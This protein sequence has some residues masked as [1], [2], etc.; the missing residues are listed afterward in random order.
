MGQKIEIYYDGSCDVC[1]TGADKVCSSA[2]GQKFEKVDITTG[3]LPPNVTSREA[4]RDVYV[5]DQN[6]EVLKGGDGVL[7]VL[8]EFPEWRW[9]ARHGHNPFIKPLILG[10][11]RII[12]ANRH[13]FNWSGH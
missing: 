9:L 6:G 10:L 5:V 12:A 2:Q 11:Y 1:S 13:R 7:R 3:N 4:W 8:Q